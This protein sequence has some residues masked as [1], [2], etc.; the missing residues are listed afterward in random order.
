M[1]ATLGLQTRPQAAE[2]V[3]PIRR[4]VFTGDFLRPSNAAIRPTQHHNIRWLHNLVGGQV[5][6]ATGLPQSVVSWGAASV[7]DGR[8]TQADVKTIYADFGMPIDIQSWAAIYGLDQLPSRFEALLDHFFS[9][10]L[11]IGFELPPYLT[12]YL[13]RRGI[14]YVC[15]TIHPVRF[16]DDIFLGIRSNVPAL[17]QTL[18]DQRIDEAYI[19]A[20]A[21]VQRASAARA[22]Q[23]PLPEN[24]A[25]FLMQTWYDQSQLRNG[26]FI[27]IA[28]FLDQIADLAK[29]HTTFL[30]KEH[31]LAP[32]P[33]TVLLRA[34]IPN[35]R[36]VTGNVYGY[37]SLPEIRTIGTVSS[38]VGVEAGYFGVKAEFLLGSP[39]KRRLKAEDPADGY[40]GILDAF[41]APD[42][43]RRLLAPLT[44]VTAPDGIAVPFKPNRLRTA[45]RSFW[46]FNEI[47][48]DIAVRLAKTN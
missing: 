43:W 19:H 9:D 25:L 32:N 38:S 27:D 4:V 14:P 34:R 10:S 41:L 13:E 20:M 17:Q 21:G 7:A 5:A 16:L 12:H 44:E 33:G 26:R 35:L 47:D 1:N 31:P 24:S 18:F 15:G 36:M 37:L 23:E 48:T 30:V 8:L 28:E 22:F 6:M 45:M 2:F 42:F 40:S 29:R 46:N 3:Q 11:V 39:V